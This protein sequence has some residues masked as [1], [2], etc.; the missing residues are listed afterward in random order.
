MRVAEWNYKAV[1][2]HQRAHSRHI[3]NRIMRQDQATGR[4]KENKD[5]ANTANGCD[6]KMKMPIDATV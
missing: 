2:F 5:R 6:D 3:G 4:R 1:S